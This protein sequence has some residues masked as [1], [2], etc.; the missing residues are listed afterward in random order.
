MKRLSDYNSNTKTRQLARII[1]TGPSD[2]LFDTLAN[3]QLR[4]H[5]H[6]KKQ[7]GRPR[8]NW[9]TEKTMDLLWTREVKRNYR[10]KDLG[11][12]V[13]ISPSSES[14]RPTHST[15]KFTRATT[16]G[17]RFQWSQTRRSRG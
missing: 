5:D 13:G 10:G 3:E 12:L 1:V 11:S 16:L 14:W 15:H 4:R 2:P 6:G 7:V 9:I 8:L 17:E